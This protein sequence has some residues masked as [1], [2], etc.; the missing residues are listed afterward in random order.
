MMI[1]CKSLTDVFLT[2]HN[3][4]IVFPCIDFCMLSKKMHI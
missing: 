2:E 4:N 3:T 1:E